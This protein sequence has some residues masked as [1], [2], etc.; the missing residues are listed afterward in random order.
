MADFTPHLNLYKPGGGSTGTITPD[1]VVDIDRVNQ[2]MDVIDTAVE[3]LD[4][5]RVAQNERN[6]QYR[7]VAANI[8]S[9][10]GM[11]IGDT[12]RETDGDFRQLRFDGTNWQLWQQGKKSFTPS[13]TNFV[14]GTSS[15]TA[16]YWVVSGRL[17]A[18]VDLTLAS[19]FTMS[20]STPRIALPIAP[21]VALPEMRPLG[22]AFYLDNGSGRYFG[23]LAALSGQAE[24]LARGSSGFVIAVTNA[25]PF[26]WAIGDQMHLAFNYPL[27]N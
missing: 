18:E 1:E 25:A 4:D 16:F 19:G 20:G 9:V 12:Y 2:N 15:L 26:A 11:V 5:F 3:V 27:Y 7:G 23:E 8:G 21:A 6:Q 17:F 14:P 10:S 22:Q 13:W 24:L